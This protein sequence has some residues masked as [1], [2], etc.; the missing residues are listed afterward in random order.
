MI[1]KK[2]IDFISRFDLFIDSFASVR[3]LN[4]AAFS[5]CKPPAQTLAIGNVDL[6]LNCMTW[7][8]KLCTRWIWG[9]SSLWVWKSEFEPVWIWPWFLQP[10]PAAAPPISPTAPVWQGRNPLQPPLRR[11]SPSRPSAL[12]S[13]V[14]GLD[15]AT[16]SVTECLQ[17]NQY[18]SSFDKRPSA[19][20]KMRREKN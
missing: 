10:S 12:L 20:Q 13:R 1:G 3:F 15:V 5:A 2:W 8:L 7:I 4:R 6:A 14:S 9:P 16:S 17:A 18:N 19:G 11:G